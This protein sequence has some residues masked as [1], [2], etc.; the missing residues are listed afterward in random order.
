M[1]SCRNRV[2]LNTTRG[3]VRWN[4]WCGGKA[5]WMVVVVL[6]VLKVVCEGAWAFNPTTFE[7]NE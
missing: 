2:I 5:V 7:E 4:G 3:S 1:S 6:L